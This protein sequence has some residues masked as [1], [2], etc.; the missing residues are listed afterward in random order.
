MELGWITAVKD[1]YLEKPVGSALNE[2]GM[3]LK[4]MIETN[5]KG[6]EKFAAEIDFKGACRM[7][8]LD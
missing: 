6:I 8:K 1:K 4:K 3:L 2:S 5:I 7:I